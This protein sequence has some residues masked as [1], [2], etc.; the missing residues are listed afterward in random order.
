MITFAL[1]RYALSIGAA[2]ALLAGCGESQ[3][4]I[5]MSLQHQ[6]ILN[7]SSKQLFTF[8]LSA[9]DPWLYVSGL[10]DVVNVYDVARPGNPLV[11][12]ITQGVSKPAGLKVDEQGTLYVANTGN[13]TVAEYPFDQSVP[14]V[15][16]SVTSPQDT[17]VDP[18]TADLYVDT[19]TEPPGVVVYR[20]GHTEPSRYILSKLLVDHHYLQ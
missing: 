19:R 16:L 3:P 6:S 2:C 13:N 7:N 17:A 5:A 14:T 8:T 1:R 20:K 11:L 10:N 18:L 12:S 9:D 15:T 4:P